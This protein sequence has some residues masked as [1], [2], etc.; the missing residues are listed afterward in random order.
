MSLSE[1]VT[2]AVGEVIHTF[3]QQIANKYDLDS[4]ELLV[5]WEGGGLEKKVDMKTSSKKS[6]VMDIP[7]VDNDIDPD[8]LLKYKKPELQALCRQKGM[9]CTGTK[10]QLVG[11]LLGKEPTSATPKKA[12]PGPSANKKTLS[13]KT[14]DT[15]VLK[16]LTSK[17]PSVI[18]RRNQFGN[19][20][21]PETSLVFDK[22][23]KKVIGKQNDDGSVE[24]L[25]SEDIDICNQYKFEY[26]LPDNLDKKTKLDDVPVDE[27]DEDLDEDLDEELK[28][29]EEFLASEEEDVSEEEILLDEEELIEDDDFEDDEQFEE[30]IDED[31]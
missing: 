30:E 19:H 25:I 16:K 14:A 29:E 18:I 28:D 22:N 13:K 7:N 26:I 23:A 2:K 20:E 6:S 17:I 9:K 4:N 21:H 1:T 3:I 31:E 24:D 5:L 11:Y 27:L 10:A 12:T 15:P 8:D